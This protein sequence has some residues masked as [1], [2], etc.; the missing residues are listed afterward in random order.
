MQ[1][2]RLTYYDQAAL[3]ALHGCHGYC[4]LSADFFVIEI[5]RCHFITAFDISK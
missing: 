1:L 2:Y 3:L 4:A 5:N